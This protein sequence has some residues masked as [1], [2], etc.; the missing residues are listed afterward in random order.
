M[1]I[2]VPFLSFNCLRRALPTVGCHLPPLPAPTLL[3]HQQFLDYG[4]SL[5]YFYA[6]IEL[7][8]AFVLLLS[9]LPRREPA[10]HGHFNTLTFHIQHFTNNRYIIYQQYHVYTT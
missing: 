5:V 1:V 7:S 6:H 10:A 4:V 2:N 9:H 3:A 8:N